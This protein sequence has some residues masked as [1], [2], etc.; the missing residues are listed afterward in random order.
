MKHKK[1]LISLTVVAV[2]VVIIVVLAAVLTVQNVVLVYHKFDGSQ[3]TAPSDGLSRDEVLSS[4]RGKSIVFLSKSGLMSEFNA[5][6]RYSD[7]Y[8]FAVIKQFPNTVEIHLVRREAVAKLTTTDGII[9]VDQF[10]NVVNT[11]PK[12]PVIDITSAFQNTDVQ[13][14][15]GKLMFSTAESNNRLSCV[16]EAISATWQCWVDIPDVGQ[17]LGEKDVFKFEN[18]NLVIYPKLQGKIVI[19][20]PADNLSSKVITGFSV[21]YNEKIDLHDNDYTITVHENGS[22]TTNTPQ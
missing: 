11:P 22:I 18:G 3:S 15:E 8:A 9:Y 1:L 6:E 5:D 13:S 14:K 16:L 7:W 10:G 17:V 19:E 21:Y 20:A 2:I 12:D 4:Y